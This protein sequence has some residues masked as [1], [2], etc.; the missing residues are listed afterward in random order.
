[1]LLLSA[2]PTCT[3]SQQVVGCILPHF[4]NPYHL[5]VEGKPLYLQLELE[6]ACVIGLSG[7]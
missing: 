7:F 5:P 4:G 3:H 6:L 2:G 1:M